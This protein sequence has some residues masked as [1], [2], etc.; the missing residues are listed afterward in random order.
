MMFSLCSAIVVPNYPGNFIGKARSNSVLFPVVSDSRCRFI[1][2]RNKTLSFS[3]FK[4]TKR[5]L[6]VFPRS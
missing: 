2:V 4:E 5:L 1:L 3:R 6:V